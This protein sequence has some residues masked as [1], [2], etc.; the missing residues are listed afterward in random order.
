[1]LDIATWHTSNKEV[2]GAVFILGD[3]KMV[4]NGSRLAPS[5]ATGKGTKKG[6]K[7]G[8]KDQKQCPDEE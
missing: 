6:T 1:L 7:G 4:L 2:V 8:K 5:K 3:E